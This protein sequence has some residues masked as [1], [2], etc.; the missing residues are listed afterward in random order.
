[1]LKGCLQKNILEIDFIEL[2]SLLTDFDNNILI[3]YYAEGF[4]DLGYVI[5]FAAAFP[6]GSI[7][8]VLA[9]C[10]EMKLKM[11]SFLYLFKRPNSQKCVGLGVW[12]NIWEF[13]IFTSIFTN[14]GLLYLHHTGKIK[15]IN[16]Q[17]FFNI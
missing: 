13:M 3:D 10:L 17:I 14:F 4:I 15:C 8:T 1:M 9:L 2:N 6:L 5:L 12:L 16:I 11:F 7:V